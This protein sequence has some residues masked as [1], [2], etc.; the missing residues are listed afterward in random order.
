MNDLD[1]ITALLLAL[2]DDVT[3]IR[4]I[5]EDSHVVKRNPIVASIGE[6]LRERFDKAGVD[7]MTKPRAGK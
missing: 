7:G 3:A 1:K 4:N 5:V 6:E 2:I